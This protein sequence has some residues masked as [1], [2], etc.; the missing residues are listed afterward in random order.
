MA[1]LLPWV[2][3]SNLCNLRQHFKYFLH[4][5]GVINLDQGRDLSIYCSVTV[6]VVP[7]GARR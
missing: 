4:T 6:D 3:G 1:P 5:I 2:R 7:N